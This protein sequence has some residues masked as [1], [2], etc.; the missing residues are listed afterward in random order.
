MGQTGSGKS[1][2]SEMNPI[3]RKLWLRYLVKIIDTLLDQ[4]GQRAGSSLA[5]STKKVSAIRLKNHEVYGDRLVF[6]DT[7]GFDDTLKSDKEGP[8]VIIDWIRNLNPYVFH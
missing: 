2:V 5:S 3:M 4:T 8:A 7:P 1:H 6:V